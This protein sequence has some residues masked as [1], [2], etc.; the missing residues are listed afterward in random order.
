MCLI[1]WAE[2]ATKRLRWFDIGILK[3]DVMLFT[4]FVLTAWEGLRDVL[5]GVAWYWYLLLTVVLTIPLLL[6]CFKK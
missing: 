3:I 1:R 2:K 5:L 6:R 4:L